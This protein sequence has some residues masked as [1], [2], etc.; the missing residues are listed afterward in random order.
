M[1]QF[2]TVSRFPKFVSSCGALIR[3]SE[4]KGHCQLNYSSAAFRFEVPETKVRHRCRN[5]KS[6]A[7]A[8]SRPHLLQFREILLAEF[9]AAQRVA[10]IIV[11]L[12]TPQLHA[13]DFA[14]NR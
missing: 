4:T 9:L 6:A 11:A 3:T 12:Q 1:H 14:G 10:A 13:A 7:L 8:S 5:F 2:S